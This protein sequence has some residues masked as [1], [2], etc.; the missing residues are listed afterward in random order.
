MSNAPAESSDRLV[1][2]IPSSRTCGPGLKYLPTAAMIVGMTAKK[3][4]RLTN[5]TSLIRPFVWFLC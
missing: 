4:T 2:M 3:R 5:A 1:L